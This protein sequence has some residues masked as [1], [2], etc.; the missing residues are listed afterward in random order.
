MRASGIIMHITSLPSRHG[1]GTFGQA[2]H[3][4]VDFLAAS[5]QSY[6]EILPLGHTGCGDSPYQTFS[7]FAGNPYLIDLD[8]L[9]GEGLLT[10]GE[11]EGV[12]WG[13]D[14]ARVDYGRLW[15]H[16][17]AALRA[18]FKRAAGRDV[19]AVKDFTRENVYWL[20]DY[21]LFMALKMRFGGLP[22]TEWPDGL[23]LCRAAELNRCRAELREDV[24]FFT[25]VQY[26]FFR[27]WRDLRAYA[28][29]RNV[30]II[31]DVPIY[32]PLDSA[33]VWAHPEYFQLDAD[34][35]PKFVA[36]V[37]PDYFCADGQLWGNPLYDWKQMMSDGYVWWLKRI[38]AAGKLF[39]V[40]RFDHFR[41]LDSYWAVPAGDKTAVNGKGVE[42]P[43][44][45][46]IYALKTAFPELRLIAED[47]GLLTES[48]R[49]LRRSSGFP[50]MKVLE[51]AFSAGGDSYY[52][53]HRHWKDSVCFTGTHDNAPLR[54]FVEEMPDADR[55]FMTKYLGLNEAEGYVW[56][57]LR[58]G[59]CSVCE[60]FIAQMQDYLEL[61]ADSRMNQPGTV[62]ENWRWRVLPGALTPE[63][64]ER[65]GAMTK[66]FGRAQ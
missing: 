27:Q 66:M 28:H 34:R 45:H 18:A 37:P 38:A 47:L 56:S 43:A 15:E 62:G 36:G 9:A 6:W 65:I 35:R 59:M 29:S 61:G 39:D 55:E 50:G 11:I 25:W 20:P 19:Q 44:S 54:Q 14:P 16:R 31:G 5:R 63:L 4:F 7:A 33:D 51:F 10:R 42:G 26:T 64:A 30:Q 52:L 17:F 41:G 32:V 3:D 40:I 53:P 49:S 48:V 1:V 22:W 13:G 12:D 57:L 21:A 60:L 2:A 23:R 46:F 58:A 8:L 24:E